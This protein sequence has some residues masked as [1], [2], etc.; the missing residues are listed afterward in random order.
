MATLSFNFSNLENRREALDSLQCRRRRRVPPIDNS[1]LAPLQQLADKLGP[2]VIGPLGLVNAEALAKD[3]NRDIVVV[4]Q[5]PTKG[6]CTLEVN[7]M[8]KKS[9]TITW[10]D[11]ILRRSS[12]G[13]RRWKNT[14]IFDI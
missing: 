2:A 10:I 13:L 14:R 5:E 6:A 9:D 12:G 1:H 7:E 3:H 8:V 4:L 11:K